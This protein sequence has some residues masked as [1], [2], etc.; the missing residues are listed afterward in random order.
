[1]KKTRDKVNSL[2]L[3]KDDLKAKNLKNSLSVTALKDYEKMFYFYAG[4]KDYETFI[5]L[6][7]SFGTS[8]EEAWS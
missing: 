8:A 5:I 6:F 7:D 1:M 2:K 4:I 3:E